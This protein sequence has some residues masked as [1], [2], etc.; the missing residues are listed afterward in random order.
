MID[1]YIAELG[2]ALRGPGRVKA[3]LLAEARDSLVDATEAYQS[4]GLDREAAEHEAVGEF[5]TVPEIAPGYQTELGLAQGRRTALL[6]LLVLAPQD[7][8]WD[9]WGAVAPDWT[10]SPGPGYLLVDGAVKWLGSAAMVGALLAVLVGGIGLRY[11]GARRRLT[12]G[13]GVL[14]FAVSGVFTV[15]GVL[16]TVLAPSGGWPFDV[17]G[18]LAFLV[19]PLTCTAMSARRCLAAG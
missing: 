6:V 16:L 13:I 8:V 2:G 4:R 7:L 18:L 19:I 3:D 1:T 17:V 11:L 9:A 12:R 10:G 14:G 15:S 5:G